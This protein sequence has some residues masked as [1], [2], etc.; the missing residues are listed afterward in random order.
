MYAIYAAYIDPQNHPNVG[1]YDI[2]G[3]SGYLPYEAPGGSTQFGTQGPLSFSHCSANQN[4]ATEHRA[5]RT[6]F[7]PPKVVK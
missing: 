1:K 7:R 4:H 2:H 6:I 3:V 5:K